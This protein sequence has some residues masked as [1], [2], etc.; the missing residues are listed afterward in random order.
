MKNPQQPIRAR[1][2]RNGNGEGSVFWSR[3]KRRY[4]GRVH[5][6]GAGQPQRKEVYGRVGDHSSA[7]KLVVLHQLT[8]YREP[9]RA[10]DALVPSRNFFDEWATRASLSANSRSFYRQLVANH[11]DAL[12]RISL[13]DVR[14]IDVRDAVN[15]LTA[16]P[17]TARAAYAFLKACFAEAVRM[18]LLKSSPVTMRAPKYAREEKRRAFSPEEVDFLLD[19]AQRDRL[20]AML[21]L[22]LNAPLRPCELFALRPRDLDLAHGK[23]TVSHDLIASAETNFVPTLG[24]TK[25]GSSRRTVLLGPTT[26]ALLREHLKRNFGAEFIFTSAEGAPIRLSNLV[27]R[28][29][30]P[31]LRKAAAAAEQAARAAGGE[32]YRFPATLGMNALRHT[33]FELQPLAGIDYDVAS[34]RG[35]HASI[36]TTY[37]HYREIA[38]QRHREAAEQID[39]FIASR[40][41]A[42]SDAVGGRAGG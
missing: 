11:L 25:T 6:H 10:V 35:G 34:E 37:Q 36:R 39:G 31:L 22:A 40:R 16:K 21:V 4:V 33:C 26:V 18:E 2:R 28:W 20:E 3:T 1:K 7:A 13:I 32:T 19:A 5:L 12:G 9:Q 17:R 29:W 42:L 8:R 41:R 15:A 23:L 30:K 38:E 27:R 24:P 14:P